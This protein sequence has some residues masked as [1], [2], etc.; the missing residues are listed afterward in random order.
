VLVILN[1]LIF[2]IEVLSVCSVYSAMIGEQRQVQSRVNGVIA[3]KCRKCKLKSFDNIE[4][5]QGDLPG[6]AV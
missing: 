1:F 4:P 3:N 6:K 5:K 2:K